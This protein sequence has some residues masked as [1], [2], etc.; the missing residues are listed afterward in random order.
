MLAAA[1]AGGTG[2]QD[3][4]VLGLPRGG[5][6]VA[7][8]VAAALGAPLDVL[9]VRKLG[10]PGRPELAM[11]AVAAVGDEVRTVLNEHV[12]A[13]AGVDDATLA[14]VRER[15]LAE[16]RRREAA[17]RGDRAPVPVTGRVAVLVDDGLATGA[18]VRA[19]VAAVRRSAPSRVV[20]AVPVGSAEAVRD[21]GAEVDA[22]VCP[23]VPEPFLAVGRAYVDFGQTG[24][25][26][27]RRALGG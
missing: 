21:V 13:R 9:I 26:E 23:W 17:Y 7:A 5:V 25:G 19:A 12:L 16:L 15:E 4:V 10:L 1:L 6:P 14:G 2:G 20:V 8:E 22:L 24:D 27:V 11:G 18:T 3:A